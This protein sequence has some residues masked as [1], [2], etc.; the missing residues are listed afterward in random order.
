MTLTQPRE[1][2]SPPTVDQLVAHA[3]ALVP[4]LAGQAQDAERQRSIPAETMR[5]VFEAGLMRYFVPARYGGYEMDWGV[6]V[7]LGRA[8]AR[9]CASTSWLACVV[10]SHTAYVARMAP[11][12][13]DDVWGGGPD[14]LVSTGSVSRN[15]AIEEQP[16]G[17][18]LSGRWSFCSGVDHAAWALVRGSITNDHRQHYFLVPRADFAVEDDWY[19]SGM[20]GTGSKSLQITDVFVPRHRTLALTTL[21]SNNPPGSKVN[22]G[23]V[24]SYNFRPFAGTALLG[25]II[26]AAEAVRDAHMELMRQG[27][28][29]QSTGDVQSQLRLAESAA[30]L[31]AASL[32]LDSL[33]ARQHRYAK[34]GLE[35]PKPE[36]IALIR[37]RTYAARLCFNAAERLV[38]SLDLETILDE[39]PVQRHFRD[40]AAMVQQI[41]VNWDRNMTNCVKAMFDLPTDI[42]YLNAE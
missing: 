17:Y 1:A 31:G 12:A 20:S 22:P 21:M 40:L 16:D 11:E 41:G 28:G 7:D 38:T 6:Q 39:A 24:Y 23:Y 18:R 29:G 14:V 25:P 4:F 19:V 5:R 26:G 30:E 42:P 15:V 34:A 32:M 9:G 8:L 10:G 2:F 13:Q 27:L 35:M 33:V 36:R 3:D 37:D